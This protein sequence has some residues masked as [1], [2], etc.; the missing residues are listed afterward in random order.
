MGHS[1]NLLV[2][3]SKVNLTDIFMCVSGAKI[4][5]YSVYAQFYAHLFLII[6]L[7]FLNDLQS[8]SFRCKEAIRNSTQLQKL[9]TKKLKK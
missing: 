6:T 4:G 8:N 9:F 7:L 2:R 1:P 5:K 3:F